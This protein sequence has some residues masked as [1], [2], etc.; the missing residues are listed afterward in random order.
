VV[1]VVCV[2]PS[3]V[4]QQTVGCAYS[5]LWSQPTPTNS[6][7]PP[8]PNQV[9]PHTDMVLFCIKHLDPDKYRALTGMPQTA[10]MAFA[11]ELRRRNTPFWL[12]YVLLPG[13]TDAPEDIDLLVAFCKRQASNFLGVELLPY[14]VLGKN[15]YDV[16]GIEYPLEGV[17]PP[18]AE[19]VAA[20][21]R[22]LEAEGLAVLWD[23]GS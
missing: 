14:H 13:H 6:T 2:Y 3:C 16:L 11:Y 12:R 18:C 9:L 17:R 21:V 1:L 20:V 5:V 19:Q 23:S 7:P 15:K 10:P 8:P 22:R 4:Q